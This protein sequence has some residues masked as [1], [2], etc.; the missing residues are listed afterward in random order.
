MNITA[1]RA[2]HLGLL[3]IFFGFVVWFAH[4][5][6]VASPTTLNMLLIAPMAVLALVLITS[7]TFGLFRHPERDAD[8]PQ[9]ESDGSLRQRFGVPIGCLALALYVLSL[10]TIGFDIAGVLFCAATMFLMGKRNLLVIALYSLLV[11]FGP[12]WILQHPMGVPVHSF[13]ME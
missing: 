12:V 7:I 13:F 2:G 5:A 10:E 4:N 3:L 11:G 1:N 8:G 9:E 6:W